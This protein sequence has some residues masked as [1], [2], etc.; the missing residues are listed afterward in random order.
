[1]L[2]ESLGGGGGPRYPAVAPE[3]LELGSFPAPGDPVAGRSRT[4]RPRTRRRSRGG[5]REGSSRD[6]VLLLYV[7]VVLVV[8][9]GL[10]AGGTWLVLGPLRGSSQQPSASTVVPRQQTMFVALSDGN[11]MTSGLLVGAGP[12]Y[13]SAVLLPPTLLVDGGGGTDVTLSTTTNA[14]TEGPAEA[15]TRTFGVQIDE[16]WLLTTGGLA[17]LVDATGGV[18]VTV[19]Q[20]IRSGTV[21]VPAGANQRLTGPQAAAYVTVRLPDED[22]QGPVGRFAVVLGQVLSGLPAQVRAASEELAQLGSGSTTT[23]ARDDLATQ[24]VAIGQQ[25]GTAGLPTT[26]L[27]VTDAGTKQMPD[28]VTVDRAT[29]TK[30]I[31]DRLSGATPATS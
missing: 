28:A 24:L 22:L 6:R 3:A 4:G 16:S 18:V 20:E 17:A 31:R 10:G 25:L 26:A 8:I 11:G 9:V 12:A 2:G 21:L 30:L 19:N 14:G 13:S 15:L 7:L 23:V 27:P 29:A 1:M 5:A